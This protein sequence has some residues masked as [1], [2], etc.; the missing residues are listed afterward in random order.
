M[1]YK[2]KTKK[3]KKII[4]YEK[5]NAINGLQFPIFELPTNLLYEIISRLPLKTI[6]SCRSVCRTFLKL[7]ED[8]YFAKTHL[9]GALSTSTTIIVNEIHLSSLLF[10]PYMLELDFTPKKSSLS[11]DH[12]SYHQHVISRQSGEVTLRDVKCCFVSGDATLISSCHGL[13]CIYS[14]SLKNPTYCICNPVGGECMTLAHPAPFTSDS[15]YLNHSGFGFCPKTKQYKVIRF[16]S[17]ESTSR[18]VALVHTLGTRSWRNIGEAPRPRSQG[19]FDCFLDGK[20]HLITASHRISEIV[21]SFDLETEKFEPVPMPA[22][23]SPEYHSKVSWINVGVIGGCL[24]LCYTFKDAY[25]EVFA[26]EE[27]GN[28][29]SWIKKFSIDVKFYCALRVEDLQKPIKF[30][31]N[32]ELL[33]FLSRFNSLVSYNPQKRTFRDI[34]SLGNGR[35]EVIAHVSSFVS[36]KSHIFKGGGI[37][38]EKIKLKSPMLLQNVL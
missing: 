14:P 19:S 37:K 27:Y 30:L 36:L 33:F 6:F 21:Y 3:A 10:R 35:A 11:S 9:N 32:G 34:K 38:Y 24:C 1:K 16:M 4:D 8:P 7:I 5:G 17:S 20:L 12:H 2:P 13:V 15:I 22:H 26:M 31:N 18:A 23:F 28:R 25:F 29:E